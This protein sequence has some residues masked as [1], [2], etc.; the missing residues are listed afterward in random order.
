MNIAIDYTVL[1]SFILS[2]R[3]IMLILCIICLNGSYEIYD[4]VFLDPLE[5]DPET[6]IFDKV[7]LNWVFSLR[8]IYIDQVMKD[9]TALGSISI[10]T[11]LSVMIISLLVRYKNWLGL[12]Y[13]GI[14]L[15]GSIILPFVLKAN[16]LRERPDIIDHLEKTSTY[17]F[18]SGHAFVSASVYLGIAVLYSNYVKTMLGEISCY[19]FALFIM[20]LVGISRIYLGVHFPSDIFAGALLGWAWTLIA[21][22]L[23][24]SVPARA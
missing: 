9:I 20:L 15:S 3:F 22:I 8:N 13:Y 17:S 11:L 18:P 23:Y 1:R 16:F 7:V 14:L 6:L 21:S 2:R 10:I 19:L 5:G 12:I 4:D 24:F